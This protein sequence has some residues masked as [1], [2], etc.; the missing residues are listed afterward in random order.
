M[1]EKL[2]ALWAKAALW[3]KNHGTKTLGAIGGSLGAIAYANILPAKIL[4]IAMAVVGLC[5]F[6]RGFVNQKNLNG[7]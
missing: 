7:S 6:W 1:I 4:P 3:V 5:T 2:K